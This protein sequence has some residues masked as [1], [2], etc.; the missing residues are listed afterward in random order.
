MMGALIQMV[1]LVM[2]VALLC[3]TWRRNDDAGNRKRNGI[4]IAAAVSTVAL[5]G[6]VVLLSSM[7]SRL[8]GASQSRYGAVLA[9]LPQLPSIDLF[10]I[11]VHKHPTTLD[12]STQ[13]QKRK[14][15][16]IF[17]SPHHLDVF[18]DFEEGLSYARMADKPV[19]VHFTAHACTQSRKMEHDVWSDPDVLGYLHNE[20]VVIQ[21]Y[22]DDQTA[23]PLR[24][25]TTSAYNG[26]A[27]TTLGLKWIDL[28][29]SRFST[30]AQ[31]YYTILSTTGKEL[32]PGTGADY[33]IDAY[34]QFLAE[35]V[36]T[37]H[38]RPKSIL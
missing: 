4:A 7:L 35:G 5:L 15:S 16:T 8:Q 21:L 34:A 27:I 38:A 28:Q 29:A 9:S 11:I 36:K 18:F 6:V 19:L 25:H 33:D 12:T 23:L 1:G 26:Q 24:E 13:P 30:D 14:Y 20:Y 31:P 10:N 2:L 32:I 37:F 3:L 22:V 17:P